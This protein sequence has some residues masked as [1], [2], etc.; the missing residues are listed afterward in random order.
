MAFS[1]L[2]GTLGTLSPI[3]RRAGRIVSSTCTQ[4]SAGIKEPVNT[5]NRVSKQYTVPVSQQS[6]INLKLSILKA[7]LR[8]RVGNRKATSYSLYSS[9]VMYLIK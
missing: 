4:Y 2:P 7:K 8:S 3:S 1:V 5:P 6:L 9:N